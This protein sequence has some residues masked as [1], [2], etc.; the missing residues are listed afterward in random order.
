MAS[1]YH[2]HIIQLSRSSCEIHDERFKCQN[3]FFE[4]SHSSSQGKPETSAKQRFM[5]VQ[6]L[7][8]DEVTQKNV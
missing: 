3:G 7:E 8:I 4:N 2:I 1:L 6:D 5:S